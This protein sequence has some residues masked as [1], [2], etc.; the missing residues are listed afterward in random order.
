MTVQAGLYWTWLIVSFLTHRLILSSLTF[1]RQL[2]RLK[3]EY[4][5]KQVALVTFG[6]TVYVWGDCTAGTN[7]SFQ[8]Q[9]LDN[10]DELIQ[11][12]R[13]YATNM[14]LGTLENT[15]R[16]VKQLMLN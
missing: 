13:N 3:I 2:E 11:I 15:H 16:F 9:C 7:Q 12:G 5:D 14:N 8:G 10:Y 4:P 1:Y 6:S